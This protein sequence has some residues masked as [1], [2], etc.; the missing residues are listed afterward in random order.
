MRQVSVRDMQ[1]LL[2]NNGYQKVR[3][4]ASHQIWKKDGDMVTLPVVKLKSVIALRIIKEHRL[5][6]V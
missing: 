4:R 2:T 3:Q 6:G 5:V 1:R